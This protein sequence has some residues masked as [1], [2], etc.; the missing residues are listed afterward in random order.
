MF[1]DVLEQLKADDQIWQKAM[2]GVESWI[3]QNDPESKFKAVNGK[4]QVCQDQCWP[5]C[6]GHK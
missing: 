6:N 3:V 2:R 4:L 1:Q 5:A